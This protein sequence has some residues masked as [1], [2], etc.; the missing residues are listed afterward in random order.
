M[1]HKR[2]QGPITYVDV[3]RWSRLRTRITI[4][5]I[6]VHLLMLCSC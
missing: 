1:S 4:I 5:L 6:V 2:D 3:A